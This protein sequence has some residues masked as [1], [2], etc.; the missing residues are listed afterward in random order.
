VSVHWKT[1]KKCDNC[2]FSTSGPGYHLYR[3]LRRSFWRQLLRDLRQGK[4]FYCHKTTTETGNGTNLICAGAHEWQLRHI[5]QPSDL[6]QV[7]IRLGEY[8]KGKNHERE[9]HANH[10]SS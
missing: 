9:S 7:M 6:A 3:S 4:H 10:H 5:G 2:P 1:D 8:E